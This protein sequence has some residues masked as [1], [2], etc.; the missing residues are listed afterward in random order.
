LQ[1]WDIKTLDVEPHQPQVLDSEEEGRT[2]VINLPAGEQ[3][4][5]HQVHERAWIVVIDGELR[6]SEADGREVTAGPGWLSLAEPK[7]RHEITAL[8]DSRILLLLAPWPGDGHP[9]LRTA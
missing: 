3:L 4:Q 1:S 6:I 5:E 7:E 8:S 2:I 9:S